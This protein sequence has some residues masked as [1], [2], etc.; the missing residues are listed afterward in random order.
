MN[1]RTRF[2]LAF[3]LGFALL[4]LPGPVWAAD[5]VNGF[6]QRNDRRVEWKAVCAHEVPGGQV[7]PDE[8]TV[9]LVFAADRTLDCAAADASFLPQRVLADQVR[10]AGGSSL[11]LLVPR[12]LD[13]AR[14][15]RVMP[16]VDGGY[17]GGENAAGRLGLRKTGADRVAGKVQTRGVE[18]QLGERYQYLL[19][20]DA[21]IGRGALAGKPL[22]AG[23]GAPGAAL[24]R[25]VTAIQKQDEQAVRQ[26]VVPELVDEVL[27]PVMKDLRLRQITV[28]GGRATDQQAALEIR[29]D[30]N[31]GSRVSGQVL[32]R[33]DGNDWK[34]WENLYR[35]D[36]SGK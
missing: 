3:F 25:A 29:G 16:E 23:G 12:D 11:M 15:E 14:I 35:I 31:N 20:F 4:V 6:L 30:T 21:A 8:A 36:L 33:R 34:L 18:D 2:P 28:T 27:L 1:A 24:L 17:P 7:F 5:T 9:R 26:T 10:Q 32:M 13:E 19:E 22:G